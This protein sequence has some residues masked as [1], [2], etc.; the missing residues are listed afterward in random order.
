MNAGDNDALVKY[1]ALLQIAK[2]HQIK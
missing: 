2:K 1:S